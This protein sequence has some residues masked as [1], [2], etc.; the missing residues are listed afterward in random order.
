M[1]QL[2]PRQANVPLLG[3]SVLERFIKLCGLRELLVKI[4][5]KMFQR[6]LMPTATAE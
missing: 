5:Q 1:K 2:V 3:N 4:G 6:K